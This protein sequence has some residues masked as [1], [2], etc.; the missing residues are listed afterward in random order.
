MGCG[1]GWRAEV[2]SFINT[3]FTDSF[4][5]LL[6]KGFNCKINFPNRVHLKKVTR[7]KIIGNVKLY[8]HIEH[9]GFWAYYGRALPDGQVH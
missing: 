3:E 1:C 4:L 6:L 7:V 8:V 9:N 2:F 5:I